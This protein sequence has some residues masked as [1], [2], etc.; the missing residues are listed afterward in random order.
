MRTH[1]TQDGQRR[2]VP[3]LDWGTHS[4]DGVVTPKWARDVA[5]S[6]N[7]QAANYR[8]MTEFVNGRGSPQTWYT[9]R[10]RLT[11]PAPAAWKALS[12]NGD[13][14]YWGYVNGPLDWRKPKLTGPPTT[15]ETGFLD[16]T[17]YARSSRDTT[18]F[19]RDDA[20]FL[21]DIE[22][23]AYVRHMADQIAQTANVEDW[24]VLMVDNM[25]WHLG[26]GPFYECDETGA[27]TPEGKV[28]DV[29]V[30]GNT[31]ADAATR[32]VFTKA[33]H[34][35]VD[36][37]AVWFHDTG[38][39]APALP[40]G[41]N[42]APTGLTANLMYFVDLI[43]SS[44]FLL[45]NA[46]HTPMTGVSTNGT[47]TITK[48]A[49]GLS[50][51]NRIKVIDRAG[52]TNISNGSSYWVIAV[53]TDTFQIATASLAA[54]G[55]AIT[56]NATQSS[57]IFQ[58]K[59]SVRT[60][61]GAGTT[62]KALLKGMY[63]A[64]RKRIASAYVP[65][66]TGTDDPDWPRARTKKESLDAGVAYVSRLKSELLARGVSFKK[67]VVNC[68]NESER[69]YDVVEP[70]SRFHDVSDCLCVEGFLRSSTVSSTTFPT[71]SESA[72][73]TDAN[74]NRWSSDLQMILDAE[75]V[76]G[77]SLAL[78]TKM[79]LDNPYPERPA[80]EKWHRFSL[81][82]FMLVANGRHL[83]LFTDDGAHVPLQPDTTADHQRHV[84]TTSMNSTQRA[85]V[86]A[87]R[88]AILTNVAASAAQR[89]LQSWSQDNRKEADLSVTSGASGV[90][91][92]TDHGLTSGQPCY[93]NH[94]TL[95]P[96]GFAQFEICFANVLS[97]S[98]FELHADADLTSKITSATTT[99]TWTMQSVDGWH[100]IVWDDVWDSVV[101]LGEPTESFRF[102]SDALVVVVP[103]TGPSD[104]ARR[105]LY[106]RTFENGL[107]LVNP[108]NSSVTID[109]DGTYN[110]AASI[111]ALNASYT[112]TITLAPDESA[113]LVRA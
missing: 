86:L 79:W 69:Y 107:V 43:N 16:A 17:L 36:G 74:A 27:A 111:L 9:T 51:G 77:R 52:I 73:L 108:T 67:W 68:V 38:N 25:G 103:G 41:Q 112:N 87:D 2:L 44:S 22:G 101:A 48:A 15:S 10:G 93:F 28:I 102:I 83:W 105:V 56:M 63:A 81:A 35:L 78:I 80:M 11:L 82:S 45:S 42:G 88:T 98:T 18:R 4:S 95:R 61:T 46:W 71:W 89:G 58:R 110:R 113:I 37:Q 23:D 34:G 21:M 91:T 57:A 76:Y 84:Y 104:S 33:G 47:T 6:Q 49:H 70:V 19:L 12:P 59:G 30:N 5:R 1:R 90:F 96:A 3:V 40:E 32:N 62:T 7:F 72:A 50:V 55:T 8:S 99:G 100:A 85:E 94:A 92:C 20:T 60:V 29:S 66:S 106:R 13:L 65:P 97:P 64:S 109:L 24:D 26:R 14:E 39:P 53:T 54:G 31:H 75:H